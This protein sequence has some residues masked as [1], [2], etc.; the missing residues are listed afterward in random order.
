MWLT[1]AAAVNRLNSP[2]PMATDPGFLQHVTDL[3]ADL[4]RVRTGR[5]FG[6]TSLY[7]D[8]AMFGV[9][10][11]DALFMKADKALTAKYL[12]AGSRAFTYDTKTGLRTINGLMALPDAALDDPDE[13]LF[14]ARLSLI[15]ARE[16]AEEKRLKKAAKGKK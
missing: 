9:I 15:P 3:F 2:K 13:A 10:F 4:G 12:D 14:W 7:I 1:P 16:A 8:D 11:G 5:M 6:G